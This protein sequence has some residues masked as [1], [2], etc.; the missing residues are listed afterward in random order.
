MLENI[1]F[2]FSVQESDML[3]LKI[4]QFDNMTNLKSII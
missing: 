2:C 3:F 1:F 4:P